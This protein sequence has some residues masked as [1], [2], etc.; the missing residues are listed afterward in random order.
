MAI[1]ELLV[2]GLSRA[3]TDNL[4]LVT[5]LLAPQIFFLWAAGFVATALQGVSHR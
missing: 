2:I 3:I 4:P 1:L 5:S